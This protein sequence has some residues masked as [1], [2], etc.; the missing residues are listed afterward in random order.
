MMLSHFLLVEIQG[1]SA[2]M[3]EDILIG[4]IRHD[5]IINTKAKEKQLQRIA[6]LRRKQQQ[7]RPLRIECKTF[8]PGCLHCECIP[9]FWHSC[10]TFSFWQQLDPFVCTT[11]FTAKKNE[12]INAQL[13]SNLIKSIRILSFRKSTQK[14]P[15]QRMM[16]KAGC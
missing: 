13:Y 3:M 7:H 1:L 4:L 11:K 12:H 2:L 5:A 16:L 9:A 8:S 6:N 15:P 14:F 10:T